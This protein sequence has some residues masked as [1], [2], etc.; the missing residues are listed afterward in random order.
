[1]RVVIA[2][3][4]PLSGAAIT[5]AS[6]GG[7]NCSDLWVPCFITV[8]FCDKHELR[9]TRVRPNAPKQALTVLI[10]FISSAAVKLDKCVVLTT[11][12]GGYL[13]GLF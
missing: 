10:S 3:I 7:V 11:V 13:L 8:L 4:V 5:V 9:V 2:L 6:A 1:M 12:R